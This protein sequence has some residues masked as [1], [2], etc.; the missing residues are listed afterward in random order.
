M[1]VSVHKPAAAPASLHAE[2]ALLQINSGGAGA[3]QICTENQGF[4]NLNMAS[5]YVRFK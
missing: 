5:D 3:I 1:H 4:S 2:C